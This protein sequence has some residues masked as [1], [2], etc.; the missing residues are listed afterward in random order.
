MASRPSVYT[1][2]ENFSIG[3][4]QVSE[5][6]RH[7]HDAMFGT[8]RR[9]LRST[10]AERFPCC[11]F[12]RYPFFSYSSIL[13]Y[14]IH[15]SKSYCN[16]YHI[17]MLIQSCLFDCRVVLAATWAFRCI[18]YGLFYSRL[19]YPLYV[20]FYVWNETF[21]WDRCIGHGLGGQGFNILNTLVGHAE[22]RVITKQNRK[23]RKTVKAR[24]SC[25]GF[26]S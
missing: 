18:D 13:R 8:N 25:G 17:N 14:P 26:S 20:N 19:V 6:W 7:M 5:L 22:N 9:I 11:R 21:S 15:I 4:C 23:T 16:V 24:D 2:P 1:Y 3:S 12:Q 10:A